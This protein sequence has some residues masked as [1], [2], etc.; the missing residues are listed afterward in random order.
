MKLNKCFLTNCL[1]LSL[2]L[3]SSCVDND[4][5]LSKD[6][7]LTM[8]L[9][10]DSLSTTIGNTDSILLSK[11]LK[12]DESDMLH[13]YKYKY[14]LMKTGT[15]TI[16]DI[17]INKIKSDAQVNSI[18]IVQL[19]ADQGSPITAGTQSAD[20]T[21]A[22]VTQ[23]MSLSLNG[24]PV[25]IESLRKI[26][27]E[28]SVA[29]IS[30]SIDD[31]SGNVTLTKLSNLVVTF[32]DFISSNQLNAHTLTLNGNVGKNLFSKTFNINALDLDKE[33][34]VIN[35]TLKSPDYEVSLAG[36]FSVNVAK[37]AVLANDVK[38]NFAINFSQS[39]VT[40]VTGKFNPTVSVKVNPVTLDDL[41]D[42]L[43]G[44]DV[45]LDMYNPELKLNVINS[46]D[47]PFLVSNAT[48]T[49]YKT[50]AIPTLTIDAAK[51]SVNYLSRQG[52]LDFDPDPISADIYHNSKISN[53]NDVIEKIPSQISIS[54]PSVKS[55]MSMEHS[56]KLGTNYSMTMN[57][58]VL[59]PF[60]FGGN[61]LISYDD[62]IKDL[63]DDLKDI[64]V[65]QLVLSGTVE[66]DIPLGLT[67]S[68]IPIDAQG[69]DLSSSI[70]V[71]VSATI[72]A[73]G[74]TTATA[75]TSPFTITVKELKAGTVSDK[76]NGFHLH[77]SAASSTTENGKSLCS[78]QYL[79][80]KNIKAKVI[81]STT[82]DMNNDN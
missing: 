72:K 56:I 32:P 1:L 17:S 15:A 57:Y 47:I 11:I 62:S 69:N 76:L 9:G 64:D 19:I 70:S 29:T 77:V 79:M 7:D 41:P 53:L 48:L 45:T 51:H 66:N 33:T 28:N 55:D 10:G 75:V 59:I 40:G 36:N 82:V 8:K 37:S 54:L 65:K 39:T 63:H 13:T 44:D 6:I 16:P 12:V 34:A 73:G 43:Q 21:N 22:Q 18:Q 74:G 60:T 68:V 3:L 46:L 23:K 5:D 14:Y 26:D 52:K 61:L 67:M 58:D 49:G 27:L 71:D 50:V 80:L 42:W 24:I 4:Y 30:V 2:F 38:L 20:L 81:G 25:E 78:N 31:A 35:Q